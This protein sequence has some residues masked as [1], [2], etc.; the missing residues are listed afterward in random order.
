MRNELH[1]DLRPL[2]SEG[3]VHDRSIFV[4]WLTIP[5]Q[6]S[7]CIISHHQPTR[8]PTT[9]TV[10]TNTTTTTTTTGEAFYQ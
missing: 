10:T 8:Q 6:H 9:T 3:E 2:G 5:A 4:M 7:A 1:S